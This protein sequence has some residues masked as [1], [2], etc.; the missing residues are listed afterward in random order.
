MPER[1]KLAAGLRQAYAV[2]QARHHRPPMRRAAGGL[3]PEFC[4]NP[5][6]RVAWIAEAWRQDTDHREGMIF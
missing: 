3:T 6:F 1:G 5:E 2:A 4:R